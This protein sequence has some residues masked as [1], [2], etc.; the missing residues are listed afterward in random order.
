MSLI[1]SVISNCQTGKPKLNQIFIF[2][3]EED[4]IP[5][6]NEFK[7]EQISGSENK[8]KSYLVKKMFRT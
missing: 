3:F 6:H 7:L 1:T 8:K 5:L 4:V 2:W